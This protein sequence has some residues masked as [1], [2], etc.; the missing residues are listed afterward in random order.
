MVKK[1]M[2]WITLLTLLTAC[3]QAVYQV[4]ASVDRLILT[5]AAKVAPVLSS[6]ESKIPTFDHVIMLVFENRN[7]QDVIGNGN[8][9]TFNQ[10]ATANVL[11]TQYYAVTHPSLP[12]YLA[13]ISGDTFGITSDCIDCFLNQI[14]LPDLIEASGRTWKTYQEDL[15]SP[16]FTGNQGNYA[17]KHDPFIYFDPI[18]NLPS[19]CKNSIV[20]LR[21]LDGD[22]TNN[23]L[24]ELA[25]IMPNLCN[26]GHD[27]NLKVADQ[28][29]KTM[30]DKLQ[31]SPALGQK[32]L[33][34]IVFDESSSDNA[35]CCGLP[36][37]AGGKVPAIILSP[38]AKNGFQDATAFSH[39]SFLKTILISWRLPRIGSTANPKTQAITAPWK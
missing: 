17:Q 39:Y 28:W 3:Q 34:F 37:K 6:Q 19:R 14:S 32:Y 33:I 8:L 16:C 13:L 4:P 38:Q 9:P 25:F 2:I 7:Y 1:I 22:L 35:S 31:A 21:M 36:D 20:P 27:C 26:S 5:P 11:L 12:N 30:V 10:L 18:R 29:V 24:P 23:K 15:P